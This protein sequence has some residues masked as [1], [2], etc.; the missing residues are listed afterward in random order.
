MKLKEQIIHKAMQLHLARRTG[1]CYAMWYEKFVE[2]SRVGGRWRHPSEMN[3]KDI[4]KYLTYLAVARNVTASTQNQALQAIIFLYRKV[5]GIKL[6][7][8]NALRAR[9]PQRVPQV[10]SQQEIAAILEQLSGG[11]WLRVS[12]MYACGFRIGEC[13]ALR[14]Q[15]VDLDRLQ[16]TVRGG[17]GQKDRVLPVPPSLQVA[18]A[19][20]IGRAE[21][22]WKFDMQKGNAGV[23]LPNAFGR[24]STSSHKAV[25]FY[26]L[27]PSEKL[28]REP[29]VAD[30]P[31]YRFHRHPDGTTKALK[32]AALRARIRKR[33][34][35][36]ILRHSFASHHIENGTDIRVL[37]DL[38][39]HKS[40]KT[41]QIYLHV[42]A[43][44]TASLR[45]PL[46]VMLANPQLAR[47]TSRNLRIA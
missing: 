41:T 32:R 4:E 28:S 10:L 5:L 13:M 3:E 35:P 14:I 30:G 26:W 43:D 45:S 11:N 22:W 34:K 7:H 21:R 39:G 2:Y 1:E 31:L 15:D 36:H 20:Q 18:F 44:R 33:V 47:A 19:K 37:M 6:A 29:G 42:K 25:G 12:L 16:I 8:V 46:E 23:P 40:I 27:F 38:M 9:K 17:K 24:K